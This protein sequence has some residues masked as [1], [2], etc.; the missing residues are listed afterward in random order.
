M[1]GITGKILFVDLTSGKNTT[2]LLSE[3]VYA[4]YLG[5]LGIASRLLYDYLEPGTDPLSPENPLII[6]PGLLVGTGLSTA[7]KTTITFKSPA[8]NAFGRSVVG[9]YLGVALKKAG[10]DGMIIKGKSNKPVYLY[11]ED[12][13]VEIRDA[14]DL[15]GKDAIET[16]IFLRKKLGK[17]FRTGAIGPAGEKLLLIAGIDFEERQSARAGGGAV[18]GSKLLK[19]IAVKG[20]GNVNYADKNLLKTAITNWNKKI[21]GSEAQKLDMAYG[22]GEFYEWVN[23]ERG[24]FPVKNWQ[25]SIFEESFEKHKNEKSPLDPYYWSPKYTEKLHPC[26]NCTKPCGRFFVIKNGKYADTRVEGIEYELLYALGGELGIDNIEVTAKLNEICDRAGIDGISAGGTLGWAMEAFE[27]GLLTKDDT[28]GID[29]YFGN[30]E[31]AIQAMEKLVWKKGKLGELLGDGVK[32]AAKKLGKGSEKFALEIKGLEPPGY[33]VRGLKGMALAIAVSV[34]GACHLTGGIYA[35]ELIGSFW[36]LTNVDRLSA[37]WKGYEVKTGEDFMSVYDTLGMCKF[38]R[39][40]FWIEGML[41]GLKAVTGIDYD[42]NQL[43][44]IGE[45]IYNLD[46]LI[47]IR[48]G[49]TRNDDSLPYRVTH[50]PIKNGISKGNYVTEEELQNMLDE[51]YLVR[52]WSKNGIPTRMCLFKLGLE[53]ETDSGASI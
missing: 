20:T 36:K 49:L 46:R 39:G 24:V 15:W 19:A 4:K 8:T 13:N 37:E 18:M 6:A 22:S 33:D 34:R 25:E 26:P 40:L 51:Y 2:V 9:A 45:R 3:E 14:A 1:K 7:S 16:Q 10:F 48:E 47:N 42:V 38:S 53:N 35:P 11:I 30:E 23:K 43:M 50:E 29:L 27:K 28:D 12:E 52:G 5:G 31:A 17:D 41:D 44:T 32:R 21:N